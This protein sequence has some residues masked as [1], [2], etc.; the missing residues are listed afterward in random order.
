MNKRIF[1]IT[2]AI[3]CA[4]ITYASVMAVKNNAARKSVAPN[5]APQ[6]VRQ[7]KNG[8]VV[9]V[10]TDATSASSTMQNGVGPSNPNVPE[11]VVYSFLFRQQD[12][13]RKKAAEAESRGED[14]SFFRQYYQ[15]EAK[16][17][18]RQAAMLSEIATQCELDVK[19]IEAEAKLIIDRVRAERANAPVKPNKLSP[20][21]SPELLVLQKRRDN[22]ILQARNQL[23]RAL[24]PSSFTEFQKFVRDKV[25]SHI[26][27]K[28]TDTL[29]SVGRDSDKRQPRG[30]PPQQ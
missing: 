15:R 30:N 5:A 24:G 13:M 7:P 29:K 25:A 12:F 14:S 16:L 20:P 6:P 4:V 18:D 10:S 11:H 1:V 21:P 27:P 2:G 9:A 19:A 8:E 22:V 17:D 23:E 3:L 28:S 26:K